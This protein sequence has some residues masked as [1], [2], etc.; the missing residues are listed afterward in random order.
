MLVALVN[1]EQCKNITVFFPNGKIECFGLVR[2][3]EYIVLVKSLK[4]LYI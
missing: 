1:F 3:D 2:F 4:L